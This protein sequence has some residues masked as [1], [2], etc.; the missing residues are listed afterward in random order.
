ATLNNAG[1]GNSY[2]QIRYNSQSPGGSE[3]PSV[4]SL[5]DNDPTVVSEINA[6]CRQVVAL[7]SASPPGYSTARKK[8]LIHTLAFGPAVEDN[9]PDR[10]AALATLSGMEAIGNIPAAKRIDQ[11]GYKVITG[12]DDQIIT[13]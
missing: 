13:K 11:V 1:P 7:E 12:S 4:T 2:Y 3:F 6:I 5:S 8:V 10:G 9:S